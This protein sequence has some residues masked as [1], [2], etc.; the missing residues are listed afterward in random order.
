MLINRSLRLNM[1]AVAVRCR[2]RCARK[3]STSY[4]VNPDAA[5]LPRQHCVVEGKKAARLVS[6]T[7]VNHCAHAGYAAVYLDAGPR[8][9][10]GPPWMQRENEDMSRLEIDR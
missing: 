10:L 5:D 2:H 4:P 3:L 8:L 6:A 7:A 9:G 1:P